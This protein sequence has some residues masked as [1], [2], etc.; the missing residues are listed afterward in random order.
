MNSHLTLWHATI[1]LLIQVNIAQE[2]TR[3]DSSASKALIQLYIE[4][5][6]DSKCLRPQTRKF[7][8]W[9][10]HCFIFT[11]VIEFIQ[12]PKFVFNIM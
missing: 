4:K 2:A 5:T 1:K 6:K 11:G 10:C 3:F 7:E 9:T 8:R 12:T